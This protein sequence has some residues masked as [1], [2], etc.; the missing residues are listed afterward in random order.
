MVIV[1]PVLAHADEHGAGN[2]V[3]LSGRALD[4]EA[5]GAAA[6]REVPDQPVAGDTDADADANAPHDPV[7]AADC[8]EQHSPGKLLQHP[9]PFHE[10]IEPVI[11]KAWLR[12]ECRRVR[13]N[14]PAMQLPPGVAPESRPVAGI[15]MAR[16]LALRPIAEIMEA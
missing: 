4:D 9:G 5:L 12:P 10:R 1:V 16:G 3:A 11:R 8:K 6:V 2:I 14:E 13:Q 15:V 7:P